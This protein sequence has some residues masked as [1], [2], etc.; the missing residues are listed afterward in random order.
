LITRD[1]IRLWYGRKAGKRASN[2]EPGNIGGGKAELAAGEPLNDE[3]KAEWE[4]RRAVAAS[5][6]P[7]FP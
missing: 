6:F 2:Q 1:H 4:R 7:S 3:Q 5:F